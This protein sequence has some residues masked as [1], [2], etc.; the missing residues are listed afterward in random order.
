M[1]APD[2]PVIAADRAE[3]LARE[4]FHFILTSF[5]CYLIGKIGKEKEKQSAVFLRFEQGRWCRLRHRHK[6]IV[7]IKY[8]YSAMT[9]FNI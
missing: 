8:L 1:G 5:F 9:R 2:G 6:Y 3:Q 7:L 4:L